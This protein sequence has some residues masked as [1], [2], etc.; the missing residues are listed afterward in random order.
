M[1]GELAGDSK[2][3]GAALDDEQGDSARALRLR[4]RARG[5][6]IDVA[7]R[8]IGDEGLRAVDEPTLV[9]SRRA[10]L[11][12]GDVGAGVGLGHADRADLFARAGRRQI[13]RLL[14][15]RAAMRDVGDRHVGMN[16]QRARHAAERR[17]RKLLGQNDR[18]QRPEPPPPYSTGW[19]MPSNPRPPS[20]RN[21][22]RGISPA[23]SQA[24]A[25]GAMRSSTYLRICAL[26]RTR[27]SSCVA[28]SANSNKASFPGDGVRH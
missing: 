10:R 25:C 22:S 15:R 2:T 5:D 9:R 21:T 7:E 13:P 11:Q 14:L 4:V 12:P 24:S 26:T 3:L 19:R 18:G 28:G 16:G 8:A 6:D 20:S 1:F 23:S 17:A 27:L